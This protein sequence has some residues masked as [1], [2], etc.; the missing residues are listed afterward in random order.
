MLD[1]APIT[2]KFVEIKEG[3]TDT[4]GEK[5]ETPIGD[6]WVFPPNDDGREKY[7]AQLVDGPVKQNHNYGTD[8]CGN[9]LLDIGDYDTAE[10][11]KEACQS[12]F[13]ILAKSL[14]S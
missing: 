2:L 9:E 10:Q 12:H 1:M 8:L 4:D 6:Y 7:F 13:D 5:A 3:Y 14:F 11:A